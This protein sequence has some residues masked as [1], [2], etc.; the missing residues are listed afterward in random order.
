[1]IYLCANITYSHGVHDWDLVSPLVNFLL[2]STSTSFFSHKEWKLKIWHT[3]QISFIILI[4]NWDCIAEMEIMLR[5]ILINS[6]GNHTYQ[7][8][9]K[10]SSRSLFKNSLLL[11]FLSH[12]LSI[13]QRRRA[14]NSEKHLRCGPKVTELE[15]WPW[16]LR[17]ENQGKLSLLS[18]VGDDE[19]Y[20]EE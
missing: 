7:K 15:S 20:F 8:Y 12:Y 5:R 19:C 9:T 6:L 13:L 2:F 11:F 18:Q 17:L 10:H 4:S 3:F 14:W 1:M 16:N